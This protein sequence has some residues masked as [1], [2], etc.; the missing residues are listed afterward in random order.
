VLGRYSFDLDIRLIGTTAPSSCSPETRSASE[1]PAKLQTPTTSYSTR[2]SRGSVS[3]SYNNRH[4]SSSFLF[5]SAASSS[6]TKPPHK[7]SSKADERKLMVL[8]KSHGD[9]KKMLETTRQVDTGSY[10]MSSDDEDSDCVAS[11]RTKGKGKARSDDSSGSGS[12]D[13]S[14]TITAL[15]EILGE[16]A[17]ALR[18]ILASEKAAR[19]KERRTRKARDAMGIGG[20]PGC[21]KVDSIVAGTAGGDDSGTV[22][23]AFMHSSGSARASMLILNLSHSQKLPTLSQGSTSD[24]VLILLNQAV[25]SNGETVLLTILPYAQLTHSFFRSHSIRSLVAS[26]SPFPQ[27]IPTKPP[28]T[29]LRSSFFDKRRPPRQS[30]SRCT[31]SC[32]FNLDSFLLSVA[33][34]RAATARVQRNGTGQ[35]SACGSRRRGSGN[36]EMDRYGEAKGEGRWRSG[37]A[38]RARLS[39]S[40]RSHTIHPLVVRTR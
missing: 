14:S 28:L 37:E 6:A 22:S 5:S 27:F 25:A 36:D 35:R 33:D 21:W 7:A 2:S 30:L 4:P 18:D 8:L 9:R 3:A 12:D 17:E 26:P 19:R 31:P 39:V 16:A 20:W 13:S 15:P 38:V 11:S 24:P 40:S 23:L 32:H 10:G 34:P 1:T 29:P